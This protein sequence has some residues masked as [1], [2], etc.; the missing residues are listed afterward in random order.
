MCWLIIQVQVTHDQTVAISRPSSPITSWSTSYWRRLMDSCLSLSVRR[1][2]LYMYLILSLQYSTNHRYL[3]M[4][5]SGLSPLCPV[6][7]TGANPVL[8]ILFT[9]EQRAKIC[10]YHTYDFT[11]AILLWTQCVLYTVYQSL[12]ILT[13]WVVWT[14]NIWC[15]TSRRHKKSERTFIT[16]RAY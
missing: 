9:G 4:C 15:H 5:I 16:F 2:K 12:Y 13:D 8:S 7:V 11:V 3:Y 10:W 1:D 14:H 6:R